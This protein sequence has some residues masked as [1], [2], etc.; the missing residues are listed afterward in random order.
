MRH[1][2]RSAAVCALAPEM[3]QIGGWAKAAGWVVGGVRGQRAIAVQQEADDG[4]LWVREAVRQTAAKQQ[5]LERE[6]Q[7]RQR[8]LDRRARKREEASAAK[9]LQG[10]WRGM[11]QQ[12]AEVQQ[13]RSAA[14]VTL[15]R[16]WK[17]MLWEWSAAVGQVVVAVP[18]G[19]RA[20]QRQRKRHMQAAAATA[21]AASNPTPGGWPRKAPAG[22]KVWQQPRP[23]EE[24]ERR[25]KGKEAEK[26]T[27]E[28]EATYE[29]LLRIA[30][31]RSLEDDEDLGA[32]ARDK[33]RQLITEAGQIVAPDLQVAL[34]QVAA[35]LAE[36]AAQ[37]E[38]QDQ[39]AEEIWGRMTRPPPSSAGDGET[40]AG[41]EGGEELEAF[42]WAGA[43]GDEEEEIEEAV[44]AQ[45]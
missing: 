7:R 15:Q 42:E 8:R 2:L 22:R 31:W 18:K 25:K 12:R 43:D 19:R 28:E 16:W 3:F 38:V 5:R 39:F 45:E 21:A 40:H 41:F 9:A 20:R 4:R 17:G 24:Q 27:Q 1:Y 34:A 33:V 14:A 6:Q 32:H 37:W 29:M 13:A 35:E 44:A 10:W 11:L 26:A 23:P 36:A 30:R